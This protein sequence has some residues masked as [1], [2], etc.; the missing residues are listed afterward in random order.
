MN[1][2]AT[3]INYRWSHLFVDTLSASSVFLLVVYPR[4]FIWQWWE[5]IERRL[6]SWFCAQLKMCIVSRHHDRVVVSSLLFFSFRERRWEKV[7]TVDEKVGAPSNNTHTAHASSC[8]FYTYQFLVLAHRSGFH[9]FGQFWPGQ[10]LTRPL[11]LVKYWPG[12]NWPN[13]WKPLVSYL[14]TS[15]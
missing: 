2:I 13:G 10:Y 1:H 7:V 9:L 14:C 3:R 12:Q 8:F 4:R 15:T 6:I 11:H 5:Q